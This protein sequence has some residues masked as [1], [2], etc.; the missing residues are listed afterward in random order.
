MIILIGCVM[1]YQKK[2]GI[3]RYN[4]IYSKIEELRS[5]YF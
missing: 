2:I 3:V 4:I 5:K 1:N